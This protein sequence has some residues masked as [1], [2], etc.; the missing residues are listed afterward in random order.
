MQKNE[1]LNNTDLRPFGLQV[2]DDAGSITRPTKVADIAPAEDLEGGIPADAELGAN[3][4]VLLLVEVDLTKP[5]LYDILRRRG[6]GS[7]SLGMACYL[8]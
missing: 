3:R 6:N 1:R 8:L 7:I 2:L 4:L 5:V